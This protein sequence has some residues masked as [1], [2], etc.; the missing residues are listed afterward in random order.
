MKISP[1]PELCFA[2][3]DCRFTRIFV[4][5]YSI[6]GFRLKEILLQISNTEHTSSVVLDDLTLMNPNDLTNVLYHSMLT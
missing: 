2:S 3:F 1:I 5:K 4:G 6:R